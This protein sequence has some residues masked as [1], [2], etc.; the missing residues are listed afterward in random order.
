MSRTLLSSVILTFI[1]AAGLAAS[2]LATEPRLVLA[3]AGD[4][5]SFNRLMRPAAKRNLPPLEDGIHDPASPGTRELQAPLEAF[6][7]LPKANSGNRVDW[8]QALQSKK[9]APH[10]EAKNPAAKSEGF[11]LDIVR[12]VKG[13]TPD[14][15]FSHARH[16]RWLDCA[17]C[18]PALFEPKK[19][20]NPMS[21]ATLMLGENCGVCHGRVA[22]GAAE[23]RLCHSK[24]KAVAAA[25]TGAA[26]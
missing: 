24:A 2:A 3:Q 15:V 4:A 5:N 9:I 21:M 25:K 18:H 22:F 16:T 11:D 7:P 10:W 13:S 1:A 17:N 23:C 19:G 26:R 14:V 12:E 20:A 8:T 6:G